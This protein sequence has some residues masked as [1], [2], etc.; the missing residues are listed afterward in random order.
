MGSIT[1]EEADKIDGFS[2]YDGIWDAIMQIQQL[3]KKVVAAYNE[4]LLLAQ[5]VLIC[6]LAFI[7][8]LCFIFY[9]QITY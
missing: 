4:R 5:W 8:L 9:K 2:P 6:V 1:K 7:I 3:R